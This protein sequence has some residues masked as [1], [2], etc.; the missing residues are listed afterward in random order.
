MSVKNPGVDIL[1]ASYN[2][3]KYIQ[4]QI[5]SV[6]NQTYQNIRLLIRDDSS[7][8]STKKILEQYA[9]SH[10]SKV[11]LIPSEERLGTKGNFS[12]LMQH[13][14]NP[15]VMFC[16][17][18]DLWLAD[19]VEKSLALMLNREQEQGSLIPCLIHTDLKVVNQDLQP[20]SDSFWKYAKLHTQSA[21]SFHR[22][23]VQN[24]VTGCT[25]LMNA[26]LFRLLQDIPPEAIMHDWWVALIA[27]AFG[28]I[29]TLSTP[30]V[31]YRQHTSNVLGAQKFGT[32]KSLK[33]AW[34][35]L[36]Q[37]NNKYHQQAQAFYKSYHE[38]LDQKKKDALEA[39]LSIPESSWMKGRYKMLRYGLI[40]S[41]WQRSAAVFLFQRYSTK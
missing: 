29:H 3:E 30:T 21:G 7:Q 22:L 41:G 31:L 6:L 27:S 18:D 14:K 34:K 19:K 2:G 20:I 32:F 13:V 15:Y 33:K 10:P 38:R 25:I 24:V 40:K 35:S 9:I 8:D 1:L 4:S 16:D 5:D 26:S 17:Q 37:E 39:F 36:R 11:V 23:L 12:T 28:T